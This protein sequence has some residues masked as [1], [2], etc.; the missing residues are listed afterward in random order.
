MDIGKASRTRTYHNVPKAIFYLLKGD[1]NP[2]TMKRNL[3]AVCSLLNRAVQSQT[4]CSR[5]DAGT[6]LGGLGS[7]VSR[8]PIIT[9]RFY[10]DTGKKNGNHWVVWKNEPHT[11]NPELFAEN[12][13][14]LL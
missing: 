8:G 9:M 6:D 4:P 1:Y 14:P 10:R 5:I 11:I 13:H 2:Y 3:L 12:T 7:R